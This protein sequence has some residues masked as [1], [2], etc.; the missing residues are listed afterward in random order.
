MTFDLNFFYKIYISIYLS[1]KHLSNM[2]SMKLYLD[3]K[4]LILYQIKI[5]FIWTSS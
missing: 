3:H 5:P 2:N 1:N 4:Q